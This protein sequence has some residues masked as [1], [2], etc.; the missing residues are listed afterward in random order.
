MNKD[1]DKK[2]VFI[3]DSIIVF[4][5]F[6]HVIKYSC[7]HYHQKIFCFNPLSQSKR[8]I[9]IDVTILMTFSVQSKERIV[10]VS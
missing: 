3:V 2:K 4:F 1:D 6:I 5:F 9:W 8:M 10:I 7:H